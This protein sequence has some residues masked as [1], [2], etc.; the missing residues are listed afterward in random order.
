[1]TEC[2]HTTNS[3]TRSVQSSPSLKRTSASKLA[4]AMAKNPDIAPE[5]LSKAV[6][7]KYRGNEGTQTARLIFTPTADDLRPQPELH[8]SLSGGTIG[9]FFHSEIFLG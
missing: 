3:P 7:I 4:L 2:P 8:T 5:V 6:L 9:V 1:M